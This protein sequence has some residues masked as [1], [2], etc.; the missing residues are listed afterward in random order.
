[1]LDPVKD[2]LLSRSTASN[3]MCTEIHE[4]ISTARPRMTAPDERSTWLGKIVLELLEAASPA[5]VVLV[6]GCR[7]G[8]LAV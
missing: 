4:R 7:V 3:G 6:A 1:M 2:E 5:L 8:E